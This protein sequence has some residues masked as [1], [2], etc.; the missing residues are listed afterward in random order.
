M[1][2][3]LELFVALENFF[4]QD[5][6]TSGNVKHSI[7]ADTDENKLYAAA[8]GFRALIEK[9]D[10]KSLSVGFQEFPLGS[11][12]DAALLLGKYLEQNNCGE[13]DCVSGKRGTQTHAWLVNANGVIVDITSD[14]FDE[15][16][17]AVIVSRESAWHK[18]FEI[19]HKHSARLEDLDAG[20]RAGLLADYER[21]ISRTDGD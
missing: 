6:I 7:V 11:C 10:P 16:H 4:N 2:F 3:S 5:G 8:L 1:V 9:C 13:F 19:D 12:D 21:I 14:Q 20:T 18:T 17:E 15:N